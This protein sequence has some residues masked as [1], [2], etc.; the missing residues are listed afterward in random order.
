[1]TWFTG[2]F[3]YVIIWWLVLFVVLPWGNRRPENPEPGHDPG[4]PANPRLGMKAMLTTGI[5]T[6]L[7]LIVWGLMESGWISFRQ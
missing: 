7:F 5:A 2:V 1:V 4:A 3:A 6:V